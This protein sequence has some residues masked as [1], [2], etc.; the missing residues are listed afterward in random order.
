MKKVCGYARVSSQAQVNDGTSFEA[1]KEKIEQYCKKEQFELTNIYADGGISGGSRDRPALIELLKD[2]KEKKFDAVLFTDLTRLG[3][4]NR[5]LYNIYH[6]LTEEA[7]I[8]LVCINDPSVNTGGKMGKLMLNMLGGIAEFERETIRERTSGGRMIKWKQ[9]SFMGSL[10]LGYSKSETGALIINEEQAKIYHKIIDLYL[11]ERLSV[12]KIA[13]KLI[14]EGIP[15]PFSFREKPEKRTNTIKLWRNKS[16]LDLLRN[17]CYQGEMT[18]NQKIRIRRKGG[19]NGQYIAVTKEIRPEA[20]HITI[21]FPP[22]ISKERWQAVQDRLKQQRVKPKRKFKE[23]PDHFLLDG[24]LYCNE[25]GSKMRKKL[26]PKGGKMTFQYQ[27]YHNAASLDALKTTGKGKCYFYPVD[28]EEVDSRL[29]SQITNML[30]HPQ[31]FA[32]DW[33]K[34]SDPLEL[35]EKQKTLQIRSTELQRQIQNGIDAML[36]LTHPE[37]KRLTY[38]AIG[39]VRVQ[40]EDTEKELAKTTKE[41]DLLANKKKRLEDF[42]SKFILQAKE[43]TLL[44]TLSFQDK[45]KIVDSIVAPENGGKV[46][47]GYINAN[48]FLDGDD[49]KEEQDPRSIIIPEGGRD[50]E[51]KSL[52]AEGFS[53]EIKNMADRPCAITGDFNCDIDR[54]EA[55][56]TSLDKN[57]LLRQV[58]LIE[59]STVVCQ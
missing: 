16:I 17:P 14:T 57:N 29:F 11:V 22:L 27:C 9:G 35:E 32:Q 23:Y 37:D 30:T 54:I 20:E 26:T 42:G 43:K 6:E 46:F 21:T 49:S 18:Y 12:L 53:D 36:A 1:Q 44:E 24:L 40:L 47:V 38:I 50:I 15:T 25:C 51:K 55:V 59:R 45:R 5:D 4:N 34:D 48:D 52:T 10:P 19:K 58:H 31:K 8:D 28:A 2:A 41:I 3:R 13:V 56:I 7:K 39:K 33:F